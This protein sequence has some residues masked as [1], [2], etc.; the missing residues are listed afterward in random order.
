MKCLETGEPA[1]KRS[2]KEVKNALPATSKFLP[3]C[4]RVICFG[5]LEM[6][7][8]IMCVASN[9]T[10]HVTASLLANRLKSILPTTERKGLLLTMMM[11]NRIYYQVVHYRQTLRRHF[12]FSSCTWKRG[13]VW[14][15]LIVFCQFY[16]KSTFRTATCTPL[17]RPAKIWKELEGKDIVANVTPWFQAC[18]SYE[19]YWNVLFCLHGRFYFC[20]ATTGKESRHFFSTTSLPSI[21]SANK[22]NERWP[23]EGGTA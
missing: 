6:R 19:C 7:P 10:Q 20:P 8:C 14:P 22:P 11:T 17:V 21:S 13:L 1:S 16:S 18:Q 4:S 15:L 5:Y 9:R 3:H 2:N 23:G 12:L